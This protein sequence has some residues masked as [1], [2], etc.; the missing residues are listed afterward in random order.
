M[1]APRDCS[2]EIDERFVSFQPGRWHSCCPR[3]QTGPHLAPNLR[4]S[5]LIGRKGG[6][7]MPRRVE[8]GWS[9][10]ESRFK[11]VE[12]GLAPLDLLF[13]GRRGFSPALNWRDWDQVAYGATISATYNIFTGLDQ[14]TLLFRGAEL[15]LGT[16]AGIYYVVDDRTGL[17]LA[18]G[19]RLTR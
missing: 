2:G 3:A 10:G 15:F 11:P 12:L 19:I 1:N 6:R 17:I 16:V 8:K 4:L 14:S 9:Y 7:N 18:N 5:L 13:H